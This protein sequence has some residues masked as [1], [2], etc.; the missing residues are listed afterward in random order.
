MEDYPTE[1]QLEKIRSWY[2]TEIEDF[3]KLMS[4]VCE[5]WIYPKMATC[6]NGV[7]TLITGGWSGN[8]EIIGALRDNQLFWILYWYSSDRGGKHVFCKAGALL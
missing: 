7:Y 6:E 4:Y 3:H 5:L 2:S 1:E 8:E